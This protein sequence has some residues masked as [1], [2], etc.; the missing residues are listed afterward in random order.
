[1]TGRGASTMRLLRPSLPSPVQTA[2]LKV[3]LHGD[4]KAF[5]EWRRL[6][7][8]TANAREILGARSGGLRRLLSLAY[9]RFRESEVTL[10]R[11]L[12]TYLRTAR[13]REQLRTESVRQICK[14]VLDTLGA[15]GLSPVVLKGV[16]LAE[17]VY[18][19]PASRH[20]HDL[21][22]LVSSR[23]LDSA[24]TALREIGFRTLTMPRSRDSVWLVDDSAFPIGLHSSL[25]RVPLWNDRRRRYMDA[26]MVKSIAGTPAKVLA[27]VDALLHTCCNGLSGSHGSPCW[28]ADAWFL[29]AENPGIDW[30]L[31]V[32]IAQRDHQAQTVRIA[33]ECLASALDAPIPER[34]LEALRRSPLLDHE[35][36]SIRRA[37]LLSVHGSR[38][39][40]MRRARRPDDVAQ[41]VWWLTFREDDT[42]RDANVQRA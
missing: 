12:L 17:T 26:A 35:I 11:S 5:E 14:R 36:D 7:G 39:G 24:S 40:L 20:C 34:V 37:A 10:D 30:D 3:C 18:P 21:D 16:A 31:L 13:V 42:P 29:L 38:L 9:G 33:F 19:D 28:V 27:P 25:Y 2:A 8:M 32:E 4:A 41:V 6:I 15:A 22:L 23:E 1:M